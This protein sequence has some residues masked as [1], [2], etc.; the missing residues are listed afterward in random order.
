MDVFLLTLAVD[1]T[2]VLVPAIILVGTIG[3]VLNIYIFTRRRFLHSG[4][5]LYFFAL[6]INNLFYSIILLILNLLADGYR[7]APAQRLN[8]FCKLFSYALNLS[9]TLSAYFLVLASVDRYFSSSINVQRRQWSSRQY[10]RYQLIF[11][12]VFFAVFFI[13]ILFAFELRFDDGLGCTTR[14]SNSFNRIFLHIEMFFYVLLA[15]F[16]MCFFGLLT[17]RNQKR[18]SRLRSNVHRSRRTET[19]LIRMLILQIA[20]HLIFA[21]PFSTI[22][23]ML[24]LPIPWR[25]TLVFR[26]IYILCKIPLYLTF[27]FPFFTYTLSAQMYRAELRRLWQTLHRSLGENR[28]SPM[29]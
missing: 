18:F 11:I 7:I 8:W 1:L 5:T 4:C 3:N 2:R 20:T 13:G 21:L 22:F 6:S 26:A 14:Y 12:I 16:L 9:P 28:I 17:I 24:V 23:L 15:P 29:Q 25:A 10:A 27:V 19:E